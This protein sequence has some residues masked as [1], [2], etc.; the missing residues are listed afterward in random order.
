MWQERTVCTF[1][2]R[3][4]FLPF[5]FLP[6]GVGGGNK[7]QEKVMDSFIPFQL[8][9][10]TFS[11]VLQ[12]ILSCSAGQSQL[13]CRTVPNFSSGQSQVFCRIVLTVLQDSPNCS[14][15]QSRLFC[16]TVPTV[17][18]H[19]MKYSAVNSQLL[20]SLLSTSTCQSDTFPTMF[21]ASKI[22]LCL[23]QKLGLSTV[24]RAGVRIINW[25]LGEV[26]ILDSDSNRN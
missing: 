3:R 16:R 13:F 25:V 2:R 17:L 24:V 21:S 9:C 8:F 23:I 14:A 6:P 11:A 7:L 12:H 1:S 5:L 26:K 15:G 19:I 18:Q 22:K 4:V 20:Y 10:S